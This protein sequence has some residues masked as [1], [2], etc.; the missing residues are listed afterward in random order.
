MTMSHRIRRGM[1]F[2]AAMIL[3]CAPGPKPQTSQ[4]A[5]AA[6]S[7]APARN[8]TRPVAKAPKLSR[9]KREEIA[10]L[11]RLGG[12]AVESE[13]SDDAIRYWEIVWSADPT[14][15]NVADLLKREYLI[16]G[17]EEF[18]NGRLE[19]AIAFWE[20]ARD[21]DPKDKRALGYL[22]R[23]REQQSRSREIL[24]GANEPGEAGPSGP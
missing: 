9:E 3:G 1:V 14:Y 8:S 17:L 5:A 7:K 22:S 12:E 6:S 16:R 4:D 23:A 18:S 21:L 15:Q 11:Y 2:A 10:N 19:G 20:K 13:R 24:N